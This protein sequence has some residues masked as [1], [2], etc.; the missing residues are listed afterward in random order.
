VANGIY[1]VRA[2]KDNQHSIKR[3]IRVR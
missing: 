3:I 2:T 1:F